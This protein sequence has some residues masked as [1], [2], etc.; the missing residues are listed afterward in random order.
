MNILITGMI[1][2]LLF[3]ACMHDKHEHPAHEAS[4]SANDHMHKSSFEEL[5]QRFESPERDAYQQPEKVL[6]YIGD[7]SGKKILD[8]GA[9]TGYFTFRLA[10]AGASVIAGDVDDDFQNYIREKVE[11]EGL[12]S[13]N[14]SLRKLPYDS[15]SL[16]P[17]EVDIAIIVNTYH[18]IENRTAYFAE[19]LAGLK[20]G[21]ELIVIDFFKK[22]MP[23]GPPVEKKI[24]E[25]QV[26]EELAAAGFSQ[27][28]IETELLEYQYIIRAKR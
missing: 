23:F 8:I 4:G 17:A 9:G 11:K 16:A 15:P 27:F 25:A 14:I 13:L 6:E 19:V 1:A 10:K 5:V 2:V 3:A 24:T 12:D 7:V 22:E 21:G 20:P 18:H 26:R 28:E